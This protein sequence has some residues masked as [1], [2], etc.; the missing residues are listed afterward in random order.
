MKPVREG[1]TGQNVMSYHG[2]EFIKDVGRPYI[3]IGSVRNVSGVSGEE[4]K[5]AIK[6]IR[7][8]SHRILV[9]RGNREFHTTCIR[10]KDLPALDKQLGGRMT[11]LVEDLLNEYR[12]LL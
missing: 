7:M 10:L 1:K 2:L 6:T 12:D 8:R 4:L 5:A 3:S 11:S 9:S